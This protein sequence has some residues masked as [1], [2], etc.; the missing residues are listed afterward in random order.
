MGLAASQARLLFITSRQNDVSA[1][2]QRVSNQNMI[3]ARDEDEVSEKY[4]RML[5]ATKL[6]TVDGA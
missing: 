5:S 1:Q 4:N 6:E 3:L 2:M